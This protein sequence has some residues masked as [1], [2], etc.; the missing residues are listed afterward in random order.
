MSP[1]SPL[2]AIPPGLK[3]AAQVQPEAS[4]DHLRFIAQMG[5]SQAVLW[6]GADK[7]GYEYYAST[8]ERFE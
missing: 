3:V 4:D 7:S 1:T 2:D 5:V 6:T 8:K